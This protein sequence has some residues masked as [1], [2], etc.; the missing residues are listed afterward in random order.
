MRVAN[1]LRDRRKIFMRRVF[2]QPARQFRADDGEFLVRLEDHPR[3][4]V[5]DGIAVFVAAA[6]RNGNFQFMRAIR[7]HR[8]HAVV[9]AIGDGQETANQIIGGFLREPSRRDIGF[10]KLDEISIYA[11]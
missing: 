1:H 3:D 4:V 5:E 8:R 2:V 11:P 7:L 6:E 9:M 10:V